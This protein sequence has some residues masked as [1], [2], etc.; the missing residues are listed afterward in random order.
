MKSRVICMFPHAL[1][2][3]VRQIIGALLVKK[4]MQQHK[5][6]M[7]RIPFKDVTLL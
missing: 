5:L 3:R 2:V 1:K 7:R 6:C 4:L